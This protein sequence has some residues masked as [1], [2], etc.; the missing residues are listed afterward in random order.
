MSVFMGIDG[1]VYTECE[2]NNDIPRMNFDT[3]MEI[4]DSIV[5]SMIDSA[6]SDIIESTIF[7]PAMDTRI[8]ISY[9][10]YDT[11]PKNHTECSICLG[12]FKDPEM[13]SVLKCGHVFHPDCI[14][15]WGKRNPSCPMC[16]T[17]IDHTHD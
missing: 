11:T 1:N 13:V 7:E 16:K 4:L 10:R 17:C 3:A 15:E 8:Q 14:T 6:W 12:S 5:G 9:Q 2:E